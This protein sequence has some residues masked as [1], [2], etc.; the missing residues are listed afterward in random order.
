MLKY[1]EGDDRLRFGAPWE[2][3]LSNSE[4][5]LGDDDDEF[6]MNSELKAKEHPAL[7]MKYLRLL[8]PSPNL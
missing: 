8:E 1:E 5:L 2:I 3:A 6:T 7:C 4:R